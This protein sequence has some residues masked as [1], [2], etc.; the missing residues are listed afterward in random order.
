MH[1]STQTRQKMWLCGEEAPSPLMLNVAYFCLHLMVNCNKLNQ[2]FCTCTHQRK[3]DR[4]CDD[5]SGSTVAIDAQCGLLLSLFD[6]ELWETKPC[7]LTQTKDWECELKNPCHRCLMHV[8]LILYGNLEIN[9]HLL[10]KSVF[11]SG[12]R[13]LFRSMYVLIY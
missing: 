12:K 4:K 2:A 3:L 6:G 7:T 10:N 13:H 9:R 8:V 11:W 5:V 1:T